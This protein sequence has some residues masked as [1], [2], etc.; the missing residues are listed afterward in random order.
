VFT[1]LLSLSLP[2]SLEESPPPRL[3]GEPVEL[4]T[5][6][7][8]LYG[9]LDLPAG[10]GPWPVVLLH[11]GSGPT[12]RDGN[13]ILTRN[14]SLKMLGRALAARGVAVLRIDKRGVGTSRKALAKEEDVRLDTYAA[15]VTAWLARLR[16]DGRFT[17]VGYVGHSEGSL[18]GL[19]AAKGAKPDAFVS[20][21][22]PGRRLTEV[23][24]EQLKKN[25]PKDLYERSDTII[26]ELEAG[27]T[28]KEVPAA[29]TALF[30]PSVQPFLISA[31]RLDP[32]KLAAAYPGPL[33]VVGGTADIQVPVGDGRR[34]AAAKP[35]ARLVVL[36][37]MSHVL[38]AV[39]GTA[40]LDQVAAYSDP[41]VPLHPKLADEVAGFLKSALAK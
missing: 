23:L 35:G 7:G 38:K 5:P 24:R 6:T 4:K 8:T 20:L 27:R 2:P 34:L 41:S 30:R 10:G 17:K 14:D 12:D 39:R 25:L 36:D 1:L 16:A 31:F 26:A 33:L 11:P 9:T 40:R 22:G 19:L 15:D 3:V 32:E 21:C 28:V 37:G 13:S 18:I 29:L